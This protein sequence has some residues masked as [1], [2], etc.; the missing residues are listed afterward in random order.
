ML[1][2]E[3][4]DTDDETTVF[5]KNTYISTNSTSLPPSPTKDP[6]A[7]KKKQLRIKFHSTDVQVPSS[8]LLTTSPVKPQSTARLPCNKR[9]NLNVGPS[10]FDVLNQ[11]GKGGYGTV[12]LASQKKNCTKQQSLCAIKVLE[13]SRILKCHKD[14]VHTVAELSI[15]KQTDSPFICKMYHSFQTPDKLFFVL[16]FCGGGDLFTHLDQ[17]GVFPEEQA[18]FYA[19]ELTLALE[20]LHSKGIMYR[21]LKPENILLDAQGH[22]V[23]TDFGLSKENM[24]G[25]RTYTMCGTYEYMAPELVTRVGHSIEVDWYALGAL[26]Y[27]MVAGSPPFKGES[28]QQTI[29]LIKRGRP[30]YLMFLS[31]DFNDLLQG[32][33]VKT[34]ERRLGSA[35]QGGVS[36]IKTHKWFASVNWSSVENRTS[37]PPIVPKMTSNDDVRNF[38]PL[39]TR[40]PPISLLSRPTSSCSLGASSTISAEQNAAFDAFDWAFDDN[41]DMFESHGDTTTISVVHQSAVAAENAND[42]DDDDSHGIVVERLITPAFSTPHVNVNY[43]PLLPKKSPSTLPV[44]TILSEPSQTLPPLSMQQWPKSLAQQIAISR[45]NPLPLHISSSVLSQNVQRLSR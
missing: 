32:L 24:L 35:E 12:Y 29:E 27:D 38:D 36:A 14:T 41:F 20:H 28:K 34:P 4:D 45:L 16:Q 9:R 19:C 1:M 6:F 40:E 15:L 25:R 17:I 21:D 8:R 37:Q 18:R 3:S 26:M 39:Y 42:G 11:I 33:L 23:L 43:S 13:K 30:S 5:T 31:Q 2:S 7:N 10:N 44:S 22:V